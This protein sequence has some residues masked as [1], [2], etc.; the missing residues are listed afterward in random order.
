[1]ER[2][3]GTNLQRMID[4]M[5]PRF[6]CNGTYTRVL[7]DYP[8]HTRVIKVVLQDPS[9]YKALDI[10]VYD[11]SGNRLPSFSHHP[12]NVRKWFPQEHTAAYSRDWSIVDL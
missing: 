2:S 5:K 8:K 1:M 7:G 10:K 3:F 11:K 6:G 12:V 4:G 9:N